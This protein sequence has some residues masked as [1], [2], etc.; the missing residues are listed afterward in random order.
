VADL[1]GIVVVFR[2]YMATW[3]ARGRSVRE[4]AR[5]SRH[6]LVS[7]A[8]VCCGLAGAAVGGAL[9]GRWCLGLV[10]IAE[11]CGAIWFGLMRDD[12]TPLPQRGGRTIADVAE[13]Y[14]RLPS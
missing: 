2:A 5:R 10:L 4:L 7:A 1:T 14:R 12:G 13:E 8:L 3:R 6:V 9:V 11:S